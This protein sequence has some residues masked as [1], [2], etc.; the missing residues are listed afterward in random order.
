MEMQVPM[1]FQG[2]SDGTAA[3][4]GEIKVL[5]FGLRHAE[6]SH[7]QATVSFCGFSPKCVNH[8]LMRFS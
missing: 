8:L 5:Y 2:L 4:E 3:K 7:N 1:D 6:L